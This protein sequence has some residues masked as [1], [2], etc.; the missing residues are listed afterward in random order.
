M[1]L[2]LSM[3]LLV[4]PTFGATI[5]IPWWGDRAELFFPGDNTNGRFVAGFGTNNSLVGTQK[6]TFTVTSPGYTSV[7]ASNGVTRYIYGTKQ[8]RMSYPSMTT[9]EIYQLA[10]DVIQANIANSDNIFSADTITATALSGYFAF[11]N[12]ATNAVGFTDITVTNLST[13]TYADHSEPTLNWAHPGQQRWTNATEYVWLRG[14]HWSGI[15]AVRV[16]AKDVNGNTNSAWAELVLGAPPTVGTSVR[17]SYWMAAISTTSF[18]NFSRIRVDYEVFPAVGNA[19]FDTRA[20]RWTGSTPLPSSQTNLMD[21]NNDLRGFGVVDLGGN[22]TTGR[23]FINGSPADVPSS[24]WFATIDAV[25]NRLAQ[26]NWLNV[27]IAQAIGT[28]YV[29]AEVTN[30]SGGSLSASNRAD[31]WTWIENYPGHDVSLTNRTSDLDISDCVGIRGRTPGSVTLGPKANITLVSGADRLWCDNVT[32]DS[33]SGA[34]LEAT[35]IT[36][37]SCR[38][39][40]F[41][42]G[43]R[44]GG[45]ASTHFALVR[46]TDVS[47]MNAPYH[48][49]TGI[50]LTRRCTTNASFLIQNYLSTSPSP[51]PTHSIL[52]DSE[53]LGL[54]NAAN[55]LT[56]GGVTHQSHGGWFENL[57]FESVT[58]GGAYQMFTL[59]N[60]TN[61]VIKNCTFVGNRNQ[62]FY[63]QTNNANYWP[64]CRSLNSIYQRTGFV[65]DNDAND[66]GFTNSQNILYQVGSRGNIYRQ[67]AG[68]TPH[69]IEDFAGLDSFSPGTGTSATNF[70]KFVDLKSYYGTTGP[71]VGAGLGNY[72]LA[73]GNSFPKTVTLPGRDLDRV[74]RGLSDPPGAYTAANPKKGAF[75]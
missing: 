64:N 56:L 72:R 20:D 47:G 48:F 71:S 23:I 75:F 27:G 74:P 39:L 19:T 61:V 2:F 21:R 22:D 60:G 66:N 46:D 3:L 51:S 68:T 6:L 37:T 41:D 43:L 16:H 35:N 15:A 14:G 40:R 1:R 58:S 49:F 26:T 50:G 30:I 38:T 18:T 70:V 52:V 5:S 28:A 62:F 33:T 55:F 7:G 12:G 67:L 53:F 29:R 44:F 13:L 10:G 36:F 57:V 34:L 69:G 31:S 63:C 8:R 65:G 45:V 42:Q 32:L 25:F 73:N 17:R 4:S 9:N 59:G 11:T 24:N 54:T